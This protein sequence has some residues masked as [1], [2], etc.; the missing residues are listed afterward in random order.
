MKQDALHI[1]L[2]RSLLFLLCYLGVVNGLWA[3]EKHGPLVKELG[4]IYSFCVEK[5]DSCFSKLDTIKARIMRS[6]DQEAK[7]FWEFIRAENNFH[8][9][10]YQTCIDSLLPVADVAKTNGYK[11]MSR[12]ILRVIGDCYRNLDNYY[13]ALTYY[14][15]AFDWTDSKKSQGYFMLG[16]RVGMIYSYIAEHDKAIEWYTEL[17]DNAIIAKDTFHLRNLNSSISR[18]YA[19]KG[20]YE[21]SLEW[22]KKSTA[23]AHQY[24]KADH[25]MKL[26]SDYV[27]GV[28]Y[29]E[30]GDCQ[31][32]INLIEPHLEDL[33]KY[34]PSNHFFNFQLMD[35]YRKMGN[36]DKAHLYYEQGMIA[37]QKEEAEGRTI[38]DSYLILCDYY[39]YKGNY[40][41]ALETHA[42]YLDYTLELQKGDKV[43]QTLMLRNEFEVRLKEV[44]IN[45]LEQTDKA[46]SLS[47]R[48][49]NL[50][51]GSLVGLLL[52]G[53][54]ITYLFFRQRKLKAQSKIDLLEQKLLRS[55]MNPH[56]IFNTVSVIQSLILSNENKRAS[57]YL[58]QFSRLMHVILENSAEKFV[59][60]K[61][62]IDAI[63]D[64]VSLQ[65]IRFN[66]SF[67]FNLQVAP[68]IDLENTLVPPMLIQPFVENAIEHGIRQVANGKIGVSIFEKNGFLYCEVDDN[69]IGL[70]ATPSN[71][72][73]SGYKT[74]SLSTKITKER[75]SH[76]SK[77]LD[78]PIRLSI[79]DKL[80]QGEQGTHVSILLPSK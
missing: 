70:A 61:S 67:D 8:Y 76:F 4:K 71:K 55:Q 57:K 51:I 32:A 14:Q 54:I 47:I 45:A 22:A 80:Y 18:V 29:R 78:M 38:K 31:E 27:L 46:K 42:K 26:T 12:N 64:Y 58:T 25:I 21:K 74:K 36:P 50:I 19:E 40:K 28:A 2:K 13:L 10:R 73:N 43:R 68:S 75:L 30:N 52:L 24:S 39:E 20:D 16:N 7:V 59:S 23:I 6:D 63:E 44:E 48:Q 41:A 69:G 62:E 77:E 53:G 17:I 3:K 72:I 49:G 60:L 37:A 65:L 15:E 5:E 34:S 35:C 1:F 66:D 79:S 11:F 33:K 56:F 9:Y